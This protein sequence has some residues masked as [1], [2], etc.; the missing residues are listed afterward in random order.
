MKQ[1][2]KSDIQEFR[3]P[4]FSSSSEKDVISEKRTEDDNESSKKKSSDFSP[5]DFENLTPYS[6]SSGLS[7][8]QP[9]EKT[10]EDKI[11]LSEVFKSGKFIKEDS[12]LTNAESYAETIREG[13]RIYSEQITNDAEDKLKEAEK[14][15]QE[16]ENIKKEAERYKDQLLRET[17][18]K[19]DDIKK[20]AYDEGFKSGLEE[21]ANRRYLEMEPQVQ[22]IDYVFEQ[23][24]NLR[25]IIRFQGEQELLQ[26]AVLIAKHVVLEEITINQDVIF[27]IAKASL[28]ETEAFGKIS[29]F[30]NPQDYE[31]LAKSKGDLEKYIKEEQT[32]VIKTNVDVEPGA[33][34]IET[35]ESVINFTFQK[36]FENIEEMLS[37]KLSERQGRLH[38]M[39]FD[40]YDF[41]QVDNQ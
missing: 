25:K 21:G 1:F 7:H 26:L 30:L 3:L 28:K 11:K 10:E 29:I 2:N 27:N 18:Q 8:Q 6:N 5:L 24:S 32:L 9:E 23:L 36:Q 15:L 33:L 17:Y 19:V 39:D 13:A 14:K 37:R 20:E 34:L 38:E 40:K 31:L 35:D 12:L 16:A 41:N 4:D 22:Q